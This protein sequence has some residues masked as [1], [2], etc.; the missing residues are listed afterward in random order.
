MRKL[1]NEAL[2]VIVGI[3]LVIVFALGL[4]LGAKVQEGV[5]RA[6]AAEVWK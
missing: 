4:V 5:D 2:A 6:A 3:A 1:T